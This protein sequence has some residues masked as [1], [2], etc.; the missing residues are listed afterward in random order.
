MRYLRRLLLLAALLQAVF[1]AACSRE[2]SAAAQPQSHHDHPPHGGTPVV[3][4]DEDYHVELVLDARTGVLQAFILDGE[5]DD[6]VRSAASSIVITATGGAPRE[7]VLAA[8]PNPETGETVGDTALFQGQADWLK[9]AP[10]FDGVIKTI[11]IRGTTF[12]GVK[13]NFPKGN[14]TGD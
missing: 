7:V 6:F 5:M 3:L 4:G 13:F 8:V 9:G 14:D 10:E 1:A 12:S 11:A 2:P